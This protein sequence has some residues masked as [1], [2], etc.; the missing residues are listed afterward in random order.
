[1]SKDLLVK[2]LI[3]VAGAAVGSVVTWKVVKTKYEQIANE[4]I[5]SVKETF[6]R[7]KDITVKDVAEAAVKEGINVD[8]ELGDRKMS[9]EEIR[10]MVQKL[11]Y[12]NDEIMKNK[13]EDEEDM[14]YR[15]EVIAP[16][17][18]WEQD[19]PT[20]SLTYYEGDGVLTDDRNRPIR[21]VDEL[22]G[23]DFASHFGE[24][25]DDS[26]F[27]RNDKFKTYYEILRDYGSYSDLEGD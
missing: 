26:V 8:I 5:E 25:E 2:G 13:E 23:E 6:S 16:E 22:V 11:G 7:K 18:S 24:Y 1:M 12:L 4:E 19:Y 10:D 21:N 15:P 20:I 14:D 17:E 27:I 9:T 3:F